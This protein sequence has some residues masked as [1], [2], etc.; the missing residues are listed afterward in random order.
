M[1]VIKNN[2]IIIILALLSIRIII[3][4][5]SIAD[6]LIVI[7]L[8]SIYAYN[9]YLKKIEVKDV[10]EHVLNELARIKAD[11]TNVSVKQAFSPKQEN[12]R[13]F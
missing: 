11:I 3:F 12:K 4:S 13:F 9:M 5:A 8:L 7:G 2:L 1:N 6:A 10:N